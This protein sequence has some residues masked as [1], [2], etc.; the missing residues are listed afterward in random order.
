[1]H[2]SADVRVHPEI[3]RSADA[4]LLRRL[5]E[6]AVAERIDLARVAGR[7]AL[8]MLRQDPDPRVVAA[9]LDN[10]FAT[11]VDVVQAAALSRARPEALAGIAGHPRWSVRRSVREALL[12]NQN[13][14][15]A[16][17]EAILDR[18]TDRELDLLQSEPAAREGVRKI[19]QRVLARRLRQV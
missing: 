7:G 11:E 1:A 14:P 6:L 13:L 16:A 3:R 8:L 4:H 19:A 2:L 10:R 12:A 9:F 18:S 5:P 17:A 15:E